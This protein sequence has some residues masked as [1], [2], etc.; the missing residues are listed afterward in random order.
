MVFEVGLHTCLHGCHA[1]AVAFH[2]PQGRQTLELSPLGLKLVPG[3]GESAG[4]VAY[5]E[6]APTVEG[7]LQVG[8]VGCDKLGGSGGCWGAEV[9]HVVEDGVVSFVAHTADDGHGGR[10]GSARYYLFVESPQLL[11]RAA[12]T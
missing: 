11:D 1:L 9:C 12:A 5:K 10:I 2:L 8:E 7:L 6:S 4:H 3:D